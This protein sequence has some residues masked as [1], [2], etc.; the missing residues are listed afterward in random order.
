MQLQVLNGAQGDFSRT[1]RMHHLL[2]RSR[3]RHQPANAGYRIARKDERRHRHQ[4]DSNVSI[5][6]NGDNHGR[7]G[8]DCFR[9]VR[10]FIRLL[11]DCSNDSSQRSCNVRYDWVFS[12]RSAEQFKPLL[13]VAGLFS[14]DFWQ[15]QLL[16]MQSVCIIENPNCDVGGLARL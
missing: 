15:R 8:H 9:N 16:R 10:D 11:C 1:S 3:H 2:S 4:F 5:I 7:F 12:K 6:R 14:A 13:M